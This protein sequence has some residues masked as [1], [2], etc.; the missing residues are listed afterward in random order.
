MMQP[1]SEEALFTNVEELDSTHP[2]PI[3]VKDR[4]SLV[5]SASV[6]MARKRSMTSASDI[7]VFF[8]LGTAAGGA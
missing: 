2:C 1:M 4:Y 6:Q 5:G 7:L 8:F 3:L